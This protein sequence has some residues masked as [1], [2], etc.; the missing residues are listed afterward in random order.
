[1]HLLKYF[2]GVLLL[3]STLVGADN[4][5]IDIKDINANPSYFVDKRIRVSGRIHLA[6]SYD[7]RHT[8][9]LVNDLGER[10]SLLAWRPYEVALPPPGSAVQPPSTM[11]KFIGKYVTLTAILRLNT[12]E[13]PNMHEPYYLQVVSADIV[14][15]DKAE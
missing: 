8:W 13:Y 1:M 2:I 15:S 14:V 12:G 4:F 7:E 11:A 9:Y 3:F 6:G 10:V 5:S